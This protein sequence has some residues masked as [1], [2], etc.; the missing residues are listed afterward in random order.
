MD[1]KKIIP[2]ESNS[3]SEIGLKTLGYKE[4]CKTFSEKLISNVNENIQD[5]IMRFKIVELEDNKLQIIYRRTSATIIMDKVYEVYCNDISINELL[6]FY[7]IYLENIKDLTYTKINTRNIFPIIKNDDFFKQK[8]NATC[9]KKLIGSDLYIV[10]IEDLDRTYKI[11]TTY[12]TFEELEYCA[13]KNLEKV[14][15]EFI[16]LDDES[17]VYIL[18][19]ESSYVA[20]MILSKKIQQ[21]AINICG[22]NFIFIIPNNNALLIAPN[23]HQYQS[24]LSS[25]VNT[26][27]VDISRKVYSF[28]NGCI[29]EKEFG[30][31]RQNNKSEKRIPDYIK[32]IK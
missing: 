17:D 20:S 15:G 19:T 25:L 29:T 7:T 22:E 27:D 23:T 16:R 26:D 13:T 24:I 11:L 8:N 30:Y 21:Q 12:D 3:K 32:I 28:K 14:D 4:F 6:D 5:S 10:Y 31:S 2:D 9:Y 18:H 1:K